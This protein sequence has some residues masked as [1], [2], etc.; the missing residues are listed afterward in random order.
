VSQEVTQRF[1]QQR[2]EM[3]SVAVGALKKRSL[4]QAGE[5]ILGEILCILGR[6]T[7]AADIGE[8]W[9]PIRLA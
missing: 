5:K 6:V 3:T 7:A 2:T 4:Q 8:D 9:P 1:Q